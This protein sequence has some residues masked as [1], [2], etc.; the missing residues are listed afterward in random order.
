MSASAASPA[1][2][3]AGSAKAGTRPSGGPAGRPA[4]P[5]IV[6]VVLDAEDAVAQ[7][8]TP[9][10]AAGTTRAKAPGSSPA[11]NAAAAASSK[12]SKSAAAKPGAKAP[13]TPAAAA[14]APPPPR[15]RA[16]LRFLVPSF[17]TQPG[18]HLA[19]VGHCPELGFWDLSKALVLAWGEG[20]RW[21]GEVEVDYKGA[22]NTEFKV[23]ACVFVLTCVGA[24]GNC[25]IRD[26]EARRRGKG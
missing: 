12:A 17:A 18:Q 22:Q 10:P 15:T 14:A 9:S 19:V 2:V 7:P 26:R 5:P 16:K 8:P 13:A 1:S 4:Q 25:K 6:E 23:R 21:S 20:H 3:G 11:S 24:G